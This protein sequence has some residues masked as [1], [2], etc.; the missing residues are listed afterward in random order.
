VSASA[1]VPAPAIPSITV[2][3]LLERYDLFLLDAYGVLVSAG[4]ALPGAAAFLRRLAAAGKEALVV[5]N[6]ASRSPATSAARYRGFGLPVDPERI[7]T[8]GLLL[9]DHFAAAG[10]AGSRCIVLGTEDSYD[11]VRE[12]GGQVV[13]EDDDQASVV[14]VADDDGYPLLETVNEVITVLLR[15][16]ARGERTHLVLPNPDLVYPRGPDAFGITSGAIAAT[17]EAVL[18]VRDPRGTHRFVPLGKPHRPMFDAALR[19]FPALDRRRVVMVGDQL[20]TDILGAQRAGLDSV[21]VETGVAHL[22]Q[23]AASE[24]HPTFTMS[25]VG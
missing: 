7:L 18:R 5:S 14:V 6:D 22:S 15:R 3:E 25:G 20:G 2:E 13:R 8:S 24:V 19:R 17:I 21:L 12:A 9:R 16:L 10:L 4:G 1:G 11:Y 23:L